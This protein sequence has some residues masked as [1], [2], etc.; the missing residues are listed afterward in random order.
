MRGECIRRGAASLVALLVTASA[1]AQN[2][3]HHHATVSYET[4][5]SGTASAT[6]LRQELELALVRVLSDAATIR[7]QLGVNHFNTD[8]RFADVR[9]VRANA[10][11]LRPS[12][13]LTLLLGPM[14]TE[15]D[16]SQRRSSHEV[17]EKTFVHTT[18]QLRVQTSW[19]ASKFVPGGHVRATRYR[20]E[21][22]KSAAALVN[23]AVYGAFEQSWN[24]FSVAGG[25]AY[26]IDRDDRAGYRR[27]TS[28]QTASLSYGGSWLRGRLTV[29]AG[30]G[31]MRSK[32]DDSANERVTRIPAVVPVNR[33]L[34]GVDDTPLDSTDHQF[35]ANAALIDGRL[36]VS[37]GISLGADS[38]SF[39]T[40]TFDIGRL[41]EADQ[42]VIDIRDEKNEFVRVAEGVSWD[43][44][45][46]IDGDRWAPY[47]TDVVQVFEPARSRY[48]ISFAS[49]D[50]R[51]IKAVSF[52]TAAEPVFVTEAQVVDHTVVTSGARDS[53]FRSVIS[54]GSIT[55]IPVRALS[56]QYAGS[57]YSASQTIG[58]SNWTEHRDVD[59]QLS[60]QWDVRRNLGLDVRLELRDAETD[61]FSEETRAVV[62]GG[63]YAPRRQLQFAVTCDVRETDLVTGLVEAR[64]CSAQAA[65]RLFPTLDVSLGVTGRNQDHVTE[66]G[67]SESR[68]VFLHGNARLTRSLRLNI[69]ASSNRST[70]EG[71]FVTTFPP[72][73]DDRV[74][75]DVDWNA[76]QALGLGVTLGWAASGDTSGLLQRYR[77]RWS[78]FGDGSIT[79]TTGY[80]EDIDPYSESR[81][82]RLFV[83]PR[84]QVNRLAALVVTYVSV[85]TT[86]PRPFESRSL[87]TTLSIGR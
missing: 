47:A 26:R 30:A 2:E 74:T 10:L 38:A 72:S 9:R 42:I 85:S 80:T 45:T 8:S 14:R 35:S 16:Y 33:A 22:G 46:S 70:Y 17:E 69:N 54:N 60:A 49:L 51:W 79:L 6:F 56:L 27:R 24:G 86:G 28:D 58:G 59:H 32:I 18:E 43:L 40:I 75:T 20:L 39:Q 71:S 63:R 68:G 64:G 62:A 11:E 7:L 25:E 12:G 76:G 52:G 34:Y 44:Y 83:A 4:R 23:D 21:D 84:W 29:A 66:G 37:A 15:G 36:N 19:A 81:S 78:P 57:R 50:V 77:V 1:A 67:R 5:T 87:L 73:R 41:A 3:L 13:M 53:E 31:G 65:A 61:R 48:E 82:R 55:F